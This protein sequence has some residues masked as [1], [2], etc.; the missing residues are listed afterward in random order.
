M[1]FYVQLLSFSLTYSIFIRV[2]TRL[3]SPFSRLCPLLNPVRSGFCLN[4]GFYRGNQGPPKLDTFT[5]YLNTSAAFD[6]FDCFLDTLSSVSLSYTSCCFCSP[7]S[8]CITLF[9]PHS[10]LSLSLKCFLLQGSVP[11][12]PFLA[13]LCPPWAI[14]FFSIIVTCVLTTPKFISVHSLPSW[15]PAT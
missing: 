11:T 15:A 6:A 5:F 8:R 4:I 12:L 2:V 10:R 7:S 13:L 3:L 1:A 14:S 9:F